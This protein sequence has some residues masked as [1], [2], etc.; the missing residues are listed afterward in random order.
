MEGYQIVE[1]SLGLI[2]SLIDSAAVVQDLIGISSLSS[3]LGAILCE[4]SHLNVLA[5]HRISAGLWG[6]E[7]VRMG[8]EAY[9]CTHLGLAMGRYMVG[10]RSS[11]LA[12]RRKAV[13]M[14]VH[15]LLAGHKGSLVHICNKHISILLVR[16]I[17]TRCF[18]RQT[19]LR[20]W[21]RAGGWRKLTRTAT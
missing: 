6:N 16:R 15:R 7:G 2:D 12:G 13:G 14:K 11:G 18:R 19:Q 20:S 4:G 10:G 21:S 5:Y 3:E 8:G 9:H 1:N 17:R